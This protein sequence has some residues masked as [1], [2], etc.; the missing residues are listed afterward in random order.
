MSRTY[1]ERHISGEN[2]GP[3]KTCFCGVKNFRSSFRR[4]TN[5]SPF[6]YSFFIRNCT[7]LRKSYGLPAYFACTRYVVSSN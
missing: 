1:A 2:R 6:R 5:T 7:V 4:I 3:R